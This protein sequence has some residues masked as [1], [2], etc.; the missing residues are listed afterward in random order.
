M[1]LTIVVA[2]CMVGFALMVWLQARRKGNRVTGL[3]VLVGVPGVYLSFLAAIG[4]P[5]W[6]Y[7]PAAVL[8]ISS[9]LVQI[10]L[11]PRWRVKRGAAPADDVSGRGVS[12][13]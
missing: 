8:I 3:A 2:V 7:I 11:R 4:A 10:I 9:Y 6:L 5:R 12:G 13:E 1:L